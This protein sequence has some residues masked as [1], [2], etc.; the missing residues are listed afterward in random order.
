MNLHEKFALDAVPGVFEMTND[1]Y[2]DGPGVSSSGLKLI[3]RTPRHFWDRYLNPDREPRERTPALVLGNQIHAAIL[4]PDEFFRRYYPMPKCDRRTKQG[5]AD[6]EFHEQQAEA[7]KQETISND[8]HIICQRIAE[9]LHKSEGAEYLFQQPGLI[10]KAFFWRDAATGVLCK[11]KPDKFLTDDGVIVDLKSCEDAGT[12]AFERSIV[13]YKYYI[14]A[15]FYLRG[16]EAVT[17]ARPSSFVFAAYEKTSPYC[18]ALYEADAGMIAIGDAEVDR[19]LRI[20]AD[21]VAA[22]EWPGYPQTIQPIS[23]PAWAVRGN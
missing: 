7:A 8:N 1:E 18:C 13:N 15:A 12:R 14:S 5:K 2:H 10:E 11:C 4:E 19:L 16:V 20:Y 6:A 22:D 9:N 3:D 17:G 23:L 21:S